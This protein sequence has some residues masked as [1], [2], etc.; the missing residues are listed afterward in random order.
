[1]RIHGTLSA[2]VVGVTLGACTLLTGPDGKRVVGI[3]EW[4]T[5]G[6][7]SAASP[8][9]DVVEKPVLE[10]PDTVSAGVPF[11][12]VVRTYG[13]DG[14][15]SEAGAEISVTALTM[16]VTPYD[17]REQR[18]EHLCTMAVVRLPRTVRA[19]FSE[20][21]EGVVRVTGRK[22]LTG[23]GTASQEDLVTVEKWVVV[24]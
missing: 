23:S 14:C 19:S 24:R 6:S 11:D 17:R 20:R 2:M 7:S 13:A 18:A 16:T 4:S 3:V 8:L 22:V 9:S 15:W 10:A 12:M 5:S 1:M 21:G